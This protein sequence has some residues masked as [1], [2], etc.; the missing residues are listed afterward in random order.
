MNE[1]FC[2]GKLNDEN[3]EEKKTNKNN[4]SDTEQLIIN[5]EKLFEHIDN[6]R[7]YDKNVKKENIHESSF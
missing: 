2:N 1:F 5:G 3:I 6:K 7:C 4:F